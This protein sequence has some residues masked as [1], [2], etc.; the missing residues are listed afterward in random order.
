MAC[1]DE[2]CDF[3]PLEAERRPL[4]PHD[5]LIDVKYCGVCHS[6]LH[7]A[8]SHNSKMKKVDYPIVPGHEIAGVCVAVGD[9]VDESRIKVGMKIGYVYETV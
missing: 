6:D 4:G 9:K 1:K 8:A 3:E 5:V 7:V 2:A